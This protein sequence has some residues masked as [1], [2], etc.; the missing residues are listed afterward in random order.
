MDVIGSEPERA[1]RTPVR[2]ALRAARRR[3]SGSA[4][5][6]SGRRRVLT[7]V[8]G[9]VVATAAVLA[10]RAGTE[11]VDPYAGT[12]V[13]DAAPVGTTAPPNVYGRVRLQPPPFDRLPGRTPIPNP[14]VDPADRRMVA[15]PLPRVGDGT[16]TAAN[17]AAA[18]RLVLGRYCRRPWSYEVATDPVDPSWRQVRAVATR[19][20]TATRPRIVI[21]LRLRW[22]PAGR[23][24]A[25]SGA[26]PQLDTCS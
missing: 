9:V 22:D 21:D 18:A 3:R 14:S 11:P 7:G 26:V 13:A 25:W 5:A 12:D 17:A 24:Y 20:A 2:S 6:P 1:P 4:P 23:A 10:L 16:P 15:G 8:V 19:A